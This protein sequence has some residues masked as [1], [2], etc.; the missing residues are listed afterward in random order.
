MHKHLCLY[1]T[2]HSEYV[3]SWK[4]STIGQ[5]VL[6]QM[7]V[8]TWGEIPSN[9]CK[10]WLRQA[11]KALQIAKPQSKILGKVPDPRFMSLCRILNSMDTPNLLAWGRHKVHWRKFDWRIPSA[12]R[13]FPHCS[14]A[15]TSWATHACLTMQLWHRTRP[16]TTA[17]SSN[18][19]ILIL[20]F[21]LAML[22]DF[23]S[24]VW[25]SQW[26]SALPVELATVFELLTAPRLT[27]PS[28]RPVREGPVCSSAAADVHNPPHWHFCVA[29][30]QSA[31][32]C[33]G[34][35]GNQHHGRPS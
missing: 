11:A 22:T 35:R 16:L 21:S 2:Q 30:N 6:V 25:K 32:S 3:H 8:A 24:S 10:T 18:V 17:C 4:T 31:Y 29:G 20:S 28:C 15:V 23:L 1:R 5:D 14:P 7:Q 9:S 26:C 19:W 34:I 33:Y 27:W 12:K 13:S